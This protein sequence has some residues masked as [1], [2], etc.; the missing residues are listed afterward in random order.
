MMFT[1][2]CTDKQ[3]VLL[4]VCVYSY[5][6]AN[7]IS[8]VIKLN[9]TLTVHTHTCYYVQL[10]PTGV[11]GSVNNI[12]SN[13]ELDVSPVEVLVCNGGGLD[14]DIDMI[15]DR[16]LVAAHLYMAGIR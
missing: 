2:T 14:D 13:S 6:T 11:I 7:A 3:Q 12:S 1:A 9:C 5:S 8:F 10:R 16:A 4:D 15:K